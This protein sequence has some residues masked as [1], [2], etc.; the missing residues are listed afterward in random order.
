ML[1]VIEKS[2]RKKADIIRTL[3]FQKQKSVTMRDAFR[4]ASAHLEMWEVCSRFWVTEKITV[5]WKEAECALSKN[6]TGN[7]SYHILL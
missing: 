5:K 1:K 2:E 6:K 4:D 7:D 3:V